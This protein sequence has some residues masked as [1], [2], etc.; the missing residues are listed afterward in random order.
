MHQISSPMIRRQE[1]DN[2]LPPISAAIALQFLTNPTHWEVVAESRAQ[3]HQAQS[4]VMPA[5]ATM[6]T[7]AIAPI[8]VSE[9]G[10][11]EFGMFHRVK[12]PAIG[13]AYPRDN[14]Y[15]FDARDDCMPEDLISQLQA[16]APIIRTDGRFVVE[17]YQSMAKMR[18][19]RR[20]IDAMIDAHVWKRRDAKI[21]GEW[22]PPERTESKPQGRK[23]RSRTEAS[24]VA[25]SPGNLN[26]GW[27]RLGS[28]SAS[29]SCHWRNSCTAGN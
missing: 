3:L 1:R 26:R 25:M 21:R 11:F 8:N 10:S 4:R 5:L 6:R 7:V 22:I 19:E 28:Q 27:G 24:A 17:Y 23:P 18:K 20:R 16:I 12:V 9:A 2:D 29:A 15:A 13:C 14:S